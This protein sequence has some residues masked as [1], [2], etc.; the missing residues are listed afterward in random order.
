MFFYKAVLTAVV[1]ALFPFASEA[2]MPASKL[3]RMADDMVYL[4]PSHDPGIRHRL[5]VQTSTIEIFVR[6]GSA[7]DL[8]EIA[9]WLGMELFSF[10][11]WTMVAENESSGEVHSCIAR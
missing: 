5:D 2:D 1:I 10:E 8:A 11:G 7:E 9:C 4:L 6:R 3:D